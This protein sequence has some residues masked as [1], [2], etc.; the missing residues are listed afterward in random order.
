MLLKDIKFF[1]LGRFFMPH[2]LGHLLGIDTHDVGG[3][4]KGYPERSQDS[5]LSCLRTSRLLEN[6]M[7]IT[8]E[9][10]CYFIDVLLDK[11]LADPKLNQFMNKDIIDQYRG[12]GGVSYNIYLYKLKKQTFLGMKLN[13]YFFYIRC[14]SKTM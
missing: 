9:P 14:E 6:K 10:G 4:L 11:A 8:I 7:C 5:S 13:T 12:F 1:R 3:Y 2:G